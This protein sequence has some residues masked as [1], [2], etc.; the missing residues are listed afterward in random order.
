MDDDGT[1]LRRY[2]DGD[3]TAF[4]ELMRRHAPALFGFLL[5]RVRDRQLAEDLLQDVFVRMLGAVRRYRHRDRLRAWLFRIARN[6]VID[7]ERRRAGLKTV[8]ADAEMYPGSPG[9]PTLAEVL[10][11]PEWMRPDR[12]AE[13]RDEAQAAREA[14]ATLAPAQQEVFLLRQAGI[15]FRE[16]AEMQGCPI[17]TALGRMHDAVTALRRHLARRE[18][19]GG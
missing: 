8:P 4:D 13:S 14:L 17:N 2:L 3:A 10:P 9:S 12:L 18:G 5:L 16:I 1:L 15:S 6:L 7:H 11:G 19:G